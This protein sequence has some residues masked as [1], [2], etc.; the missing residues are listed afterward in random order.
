MAVE[1][2][3]GAPSWVDGMAAIAEHHIRRAEDQIWY[4]EQAWQ[5][6][7]WSTPEELSAKLLAARVETSKVVG[8]ATDALRMS[9]LVVDALEP[10]GYVQ[11][12]LPGEGCPMDPRTVVW[13]T[14]L[15]R[16][17]NLR[18]AWASR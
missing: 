12:T 9:T 3:S 10:F 4:A 16:W 11:A 14:Q 1:R 5:A 15:E 13:A 8:L 2:K 17:E 6:I 7:D 18:A